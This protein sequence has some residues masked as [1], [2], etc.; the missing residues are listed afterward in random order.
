[1]FTGSASV[2]V[3]RQHRQRG[4]FDAFVD[5]GAGFVGRGLAIDRAVLDIAV[6]HLAGF[7]G[8]ALA[9]IVGVPG[10]V[11]AQFLQLGAQLALLR[12]Q[13]RCRPRRGYFRACDFCGCRRLG[14]RNFA[15]PLADDLRGH[16]GALDLDRAAGWAAHQLALLL[17]LIGRGALKPAFEGVTPL[18]AQAV[19]DHAEPRTRCRCSGPALGSAMPKRLPCCSDGTVLRA[20]S[21][22]AGS[23]SARNTPGSTPPSARISPQ[24][25]MISECPYVSRLFSCRPH[26]A[27]ANTKQPVSMARARSSVCQC[28][29]PVFLVKADG[30]VR[31]DAP[32]SASAR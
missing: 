31:N 16:D 2:P 18:A 26:W 25:A 4:D 24:G 13:Q 5:Q 6:M 27:A 15:A 23:I 21:T 20:V 17:A 3:V 19:A 22:L 8:E 14:R 12:H 32:L 29:S 28:A 9:D 30:T 7:V 10:D 1:M 11:I